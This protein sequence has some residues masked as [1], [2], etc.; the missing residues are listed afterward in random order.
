VHT[1]AYGPRPSARAAN[2][3]L[4]ANVDQVFYRGLA[5]LPEERYANCR[6]FVAVLERAL[7]PGDDVET[8]ATVLPLGATPA[9]P[10]RGGKPFP[11]IV[12]GAVAAT[13]L[14][15]AGLGYVWMHRAPV[16]APKAPP[17]AAVQAAL[18]LSPEQQLALPTVMFQ[19][20][21]DSVP[22]GTGAM[23]IWK[24]SGATKVKIEPEVGTV[25]ATGYVVVKPAQTTLYKLTT[26]D[27][28]STA[29]GEVLV[30][31]TLAPRDVVRP[32]PADSEKPVRPQDA[33][34]S[35]GAGQFYLDGESKLRDKQ[36]TEGVA[37][38]TKAGALGEVRAMLELGGIYGQEGDGH[39][40]DRQRQLYW[41][42]KA[43]DKGD[44]AGMIRLG[45]IYEVGSPGV[46]PNLAQAA[47]WYSKAVAHGSIPATYILAT[48]YE[49]GRGV[50]RDLAQARKLYQRAADYGYQDA[51]KRLERSPRVPPAAPTTQREAVPTP[52]AIEL[53]QTTAQVMA[54]IGRPEKIVTLP[55]GK[56]IYAYKDFKVIFVKGIV[57]DIQ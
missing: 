36:L 50:S 49:N 2:P 35:A 12:G 31:V 4:P 41:Y 5:K 42:Q 32:K 56:Q 23:L 43:A 46:P 39:I 20:L 16:V 52:P 57:V 48:M 9:V 26:I 19:A 22:A 34:V 33:N 11:Y 6:E 44:V 40:Y 7:S 3:E 1:V 29:R 13:L 54:S 25:P 21:S 14:I 10:N 51:R 30:E 55:D 27:A 53:G 8:R 17:G 45:G 18:P 24:V 15:A 47:I 37:L 28:V 38:L